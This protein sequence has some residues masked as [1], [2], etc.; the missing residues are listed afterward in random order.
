MIFVE[1]W[2]LMHADATIAAAECVLAW[3]LQQ[4]YAAK[5]VYM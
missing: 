4:D 5:G 2:F 1:R 3:D